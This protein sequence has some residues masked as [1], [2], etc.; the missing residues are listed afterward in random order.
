MRPLKAEY[1]RLRV[2][3]EKPRSSPPVPVTITN[4]DGA[5]STLRTQE[6]FN[7]AV[8]GALSTRFTLAQRAPIMQEQ[9]V[10]R[11]VCWVMGRLF[12]RYLMEMEIIPF[13]ATPTTTPFGY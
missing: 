6:G 8:G 11:L 4:S 10:Q 12:S 7:S 2:F 1:T 13:L 3:T 9:S 5:M